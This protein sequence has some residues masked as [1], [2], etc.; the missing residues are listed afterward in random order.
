MQLRQLYNFFLDELKPIYGLDETASM[1][2]MIFEHFAGANRT[3]IISQPD[4]T[5]KAEEISALENALAQLKKHVP[6]Q[7]II[8][9]AWFAGNKFKV[10]PAVLIPR[11]ETEELV[12]EAVDFIKTNHKKTVLDIGSGSGC[13]PISIKK[14]LPHTKVTSVD[15]SAAAIQIAEENAKENDSSI[16]F[17]QIDFLDSKNWDSLPQYDVI[18]SNP[19]YIP[20]KEK[21]L[22]DANVT[23]HE[24]HLALFVP[25]NDAL[26][27][28]EKI[29]AFG[30]KHLAKGGKIFMETHEAF[31]QDVAAHFTQQGYDAIVKKD[32]F[33]KNRMVVASRFR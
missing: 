1:A 24:P 26:I 22:L 10:S 7:Y 18:I 12:M 29:A 28:Y 3:V 2:N 30:L 19:P 20:E 11:P 5:L 32:F 21:A 27:F 13:I 4:K 6:V 16:N 14:K 31:T 33:G 8:G 17:L 25:D 15:I 23:E 9:H